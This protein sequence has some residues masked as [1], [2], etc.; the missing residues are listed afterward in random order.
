M[1]DQIDPYLGQYDRLE[2]LWTV[3]AANLDLIIGTM[4]PNE[5]A[6]QP[7]LIETMDGT[8][9]TLIAAEF[10]TRQLAVPGGLIVL[11]VRWGADLLTMVRMRNMFEPLNKLRPIIG[12]DTFEGHVGTSPEDG[13]TH[14]V[15]PGFLNVTEDWGDILYDLMRLMARRD[16]VSSDVLVGLVTGDARETIHEFLKDQPAFQ[17]SGIIVDFDLYEPTLECLLALTPR[18]TVGTVLWFDEVNAGTYPGEAQALREWQ[19][20]T[21]VRL[22]WWRPSWGVHEILATVTHLPRQVSSP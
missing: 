6:K 18:M 2:S 21:G 9:R 3:L 14:Q 17:V 15:Q 19:A 13:E 8:V 5:F 7:R 11:G 4:G 12:F 16:Q 20:Q 10:Y 22:E 1:T